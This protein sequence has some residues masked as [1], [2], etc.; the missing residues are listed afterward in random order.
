MS[1][2]E[3]Q[4]EAGSENKASEEISSEDKLENDNE[5]FLYMHKPENQGSSMQWNSAFCR[6]PGY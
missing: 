4:D 5:D 1:Y 3:P 2:K 6:K